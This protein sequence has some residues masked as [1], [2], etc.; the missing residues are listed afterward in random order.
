MGGRGGDGVLRIHE[1]E[2]KDRSNEEQLVIQSSSW[3]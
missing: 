1:E 2:G 3:S